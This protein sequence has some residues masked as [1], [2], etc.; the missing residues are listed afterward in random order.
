MQHNVARNPR[1]FIPWRISISRPDVCARV[2]K[3]KSDSLVADIVKKGIFG[4]TAAYVYTIEWQK[5]KGLPHMHLLVTLH[6]DSKVHDPKDIDKFI[7]AEIP[8]PV[9]NPRL[10]KAVMKHM[11]HGPCGKHFPKSPCMDSAGNSNVK[12]C[13][14]EFP[15]EFQPET[16]MSEYSYPV[17]R[18]R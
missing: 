3:I 1:I 14:K 16:E 5:R 17:Y 10:Y 2:F 12:I 8:D 6:H 7:S 9:K 4:L 13:S 15:K 11:I 18:R